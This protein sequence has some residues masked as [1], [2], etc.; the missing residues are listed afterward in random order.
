MLKPEF[1]RTRL[2][3]NIEGRALVWY[4]LGLVALLALIGWGLSRVAPPPAPK[5]GVPPRA[6]VSP[7]FGGF[8]MAYPMRQPGMPGPSS[9]AAAYGLPHEPTPA[10]AIAADP[11]LL[12][13]GSIVSI[14]GYAGDAVVPVLDVGGAIKGNKLDV[15]YA[16]H[17]RARQWGV[18]EL[19][20][21]VWEY[22]DGQ[23]SGFKRLRRNP[24]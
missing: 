3:E 18:Q 23:P 13:L 19:E 5:K 4:A 17:A 2:P 10:E 21:I 22:A 9:G 14:P 12:P 7:Q 15:L 6:A 1:I 8:P 11:K 24:K 20:V 16:T